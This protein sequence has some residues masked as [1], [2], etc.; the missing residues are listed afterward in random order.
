[1]CP[2]DN[3]QDQLNG[4]NFGFLTLNYSQTI[5]AA[6]CL[7]LHSKIWMQG[8]SF[9]NCLPIVALL[10]LNIV[11]PIWL[12]RQLLSLF[13]ALNFGLQWNLRPYFCVFR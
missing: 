11:N 8:I 9:F 3:G 2:H 12:V 4:S 7:H 10:Q 5:Q 6:M 1:M 13:R